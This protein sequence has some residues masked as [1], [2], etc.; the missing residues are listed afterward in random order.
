LLTSSLQHLPISFRG[1][2]EEALD[3]YCAQL[4]FTDINGR[5][6][7]FPTYGQGLENSFKSF[8]EW[9]NIILSFGLAGLRV[10]YVQCV[11]KYLLA[12]M[13][14]NNCMEITLFLVQ[15]GV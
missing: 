2:T 8:A 13:G 6:P 9:I 15:K 4:Q 10:I 1:T 14:L 5:A 11:K 3:I 7:V 12:Q